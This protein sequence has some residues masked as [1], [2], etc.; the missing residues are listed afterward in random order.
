MGCIGPPLYF[1]PMVTAKDTSGGVPVSQRMATN[2]SV[3]L[4]GN[5]RWNKVPEIYHTLGRKRKAAV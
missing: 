3:F 2:T 4:M 5:L 1:T